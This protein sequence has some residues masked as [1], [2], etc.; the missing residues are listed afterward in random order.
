MARDCTRRRSRSPRQR[1]NTGRNDVCNKCGGKGHWARECSSRE[2]GGQ[3]CYVCGKEGHISRNC[4]QNTGGGGGGD[5]KCYS[6]GKEGHFA[7]DC[8][9]KE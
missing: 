5:R 8:R 1:T 6:C 7:K 9:V 2:E 3:K 4:R